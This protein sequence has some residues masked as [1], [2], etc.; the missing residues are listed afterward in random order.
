MYAVM[1]PGVNQPSIIT[2]LSMI[3]IPLLT[4]LF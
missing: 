3:S 2:L 1:R 4:M